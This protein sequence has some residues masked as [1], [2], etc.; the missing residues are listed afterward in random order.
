MPANLTPD[1][2]R[3]GQSFREARTSEEKLAAL[4]QMLA[5]IPKHKGT[6]KMQAD[7]KHRIAKLRSQEASAK[8]TKHVDP[9]HIA[10]SG[11]G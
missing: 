4:E 8:R 10:P 6:D 5:T 1:Y 9:Y 2:L 3:A 11:P 7:I